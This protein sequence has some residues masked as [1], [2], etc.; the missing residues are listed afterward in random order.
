MLEQ[1]TREDFEKLVGQ[2]FEI[3]FGEAGTLSGKLAKVSAG[4]APPQD[5]EPFSIEFQCPQ[6]APV[7]QGMYTVGHAEIGEIALFM[8]PVYGDADGVTFE[9][10][11]T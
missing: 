9:A 4:N 8:V 5:R 11:F 1:L 3:D 2:S 6:P 7:E 10:V